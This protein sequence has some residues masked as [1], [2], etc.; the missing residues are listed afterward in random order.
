MKTIFAKNANK[1][2]AIGNIKEKLKTII[3][4]QDMAI[5]SVKDIISRAIFIQKENRVNAVL[6]L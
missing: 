4:D 2:I 1:L 3:Y 6:F 5:E